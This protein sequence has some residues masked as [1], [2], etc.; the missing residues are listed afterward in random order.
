MP[1]PKWLSDAAAKVP[2]VSVKG[3]QVANGPAINFDD[4]LYAELYT[5]YITGQLNE[6]DASAVDEI[7]FLRDVANQ[8]TAK[9]ISAMQNKLAADEEPKAAEPKAKPSKIE[10][11]EPAE[12]AP[13]TEKK[14]EKG[15][16]GKVTHK[17][18]KLP[19]PGTSKWREVR[20]NERLDTWQSISTERTVQNFN[21]E[22]EAIDGLRDM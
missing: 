13:K 12:V 3:Y 15:E 17:N 6:V 1:I 7:E 21:S 9:L 8:A 2:Q 16:E 14:E 5:K 11:V 22:D 18:D 10:A 19:E 20:Y 4:P